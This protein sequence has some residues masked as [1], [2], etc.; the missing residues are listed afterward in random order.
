VDGFRGGEVWKLLS[1]EVFCFIFVAAD[2]DSLRGD[3]RDA[4]DADDA[5]DSRLGG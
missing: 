1:G 3:K 4:E 2:F 5:D